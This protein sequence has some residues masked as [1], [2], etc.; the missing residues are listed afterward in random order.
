MLLLLLLVLLVVVLLLLLL[1]LLLLTAAALRAPRD[2]VRPRRTLPAGPILPCSQVYR[3]PIDIF[4]SVTAAGTAP[5]RAGS[6][7]APRR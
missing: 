6:W 4:P 7:T 3:L 5:A 2:R 1:V